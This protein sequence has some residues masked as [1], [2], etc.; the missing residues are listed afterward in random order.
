MPAG[1]PGQGTRWAILPKPRGR[2]CGEAAWVRWGRRP[3]WWWGLVPPDTTT[4]G[5][6][7][8]LGFSPVRGRPQNSRSLG[9]SGALGVLFF[10][11]FWRKNVGKSLGKKNHH[12]NLRRRVLPPPTV[13]FPPFTSKLQNPLE[14]HPQLSVSE[15]QGQVPG[16]PLMTCVTLGNAFHL[17]SVSSSVKW[18]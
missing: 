13:S 11:Q 4:H 12:C 6:C 16:L 5:L 17:T 1:G 14:G 7:G 3:G 2:P 15:T 9:L 8:A 18:G 10:G